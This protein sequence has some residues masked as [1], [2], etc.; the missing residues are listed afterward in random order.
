MRH[1]DDGNH[2]EASARHANADHL[3]GLAAECLL[4]AILLDFL[5]G[6]MGR[7]KP[8]TVTP[9]GRVV[10][11]GHLPDVW[12]HLA[13]HAQGRSGAQ[14][15]TLISSDNPFRGSWQVWD[16]YA[17]GTAVTPEICRSHLE[18]A[19]TV[20]RLHQQAQLDGGLS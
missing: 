11:Y 13:L 6:R 3:A 20:A 8:E 12:D 1:L 16:R 2:L 10:E 5:G 7:I 17:N 4:K 14:F 18:A 15:L 19:T 9:E